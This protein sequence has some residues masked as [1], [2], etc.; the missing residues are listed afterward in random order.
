MR[1]HFVGKMS[2]SGDSLMADSE[3][4]LAGIHKH[5]P[6][7]GLE[8]F[9]QWFGDVDGAL[10]PFNLGHPG[11]SYNVT[12]GQH[13]AAL[14][15]KWTSEA[16]A[17]GRQ[18]YFTILGITIG[19]A[20][21][22][23]AG[24]SNFGV[25]GHG[26]NDFSPVLSQ[27]YDSIY[28]AS[29]SAGQID[30]YLDGIEA[31][32][33]DGFSTYRSKGA[34]LLLLLDAPSYNFSPYLRTLYT[35]AVKRE[36][37]EVVIEDL[38]ARILASA[39]TRGVPLVHIHA[40]YDYLMGD[41]AAPIATRTI[42]GNTVQMLEGDK[43]SPYSAFQGDYVHDGNILALLK[44]DLILHAFSKYGLPYTRQSESTLC[45]WA[46]MPTGGANTLNLDLDGFITLPPAVPV[47]RD[48]LYATPKYQRDT[49][50][51]GA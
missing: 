29:W 14:T 12:A 16:P 3:G 46:G 11:A 31:S 13:G 38:N 19:I 10:R 6:R 40:L 45:G 47:T 5:W 51:I 23:E 43:D 8:R 36:R 39:A 35:D 1:W 37:V 33:W 32:L 17:H 28:N 30:T 18:V 20:A 7:H 34:G 50:W 4:P 48:Q 24:S 44:L 21:N 41:H 2:Q 15:T 27:V 22:L 49:L 26:A 42:G 9:P 25:V